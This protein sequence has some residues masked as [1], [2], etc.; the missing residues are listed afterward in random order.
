MDL[1]Q[2]CQRWLE[3]GAYDRVVNRI[4][5]EPTAILTPKLAQLLHS[6][7]Q[8]QQKQEQDDFVAFVCQDL[9]ADCAYNLHDVSILLDAISDQWGL[10]HHMFLTGASSRVWNL[11]WFKSNKS[12][13]Y[14]TALTLG[15]MPLG[16]DAK[17][18]P[19]HVELMM[20]LPPKWKMG[21]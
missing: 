2:Q 8:G 21:F 15:L 7:L 14:V 16:V 3:Q 13:P 10:F 11:L 5:S 6:A 9:A 19:T 18:R 17:G 12:R 4:L 1:L 20:R